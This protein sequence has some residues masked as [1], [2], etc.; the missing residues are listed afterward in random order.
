MN[1]NQNSQIERARVRRN[2]PTADLD[3]ETEGASQALHTPY[4]RSIHSN[5]T[6]E[7]SHSRAI[8]PS[9]RLLS[10]LSGH[11]GPRPA[12]RGPTTLARS[13]SPSSSTRTPM[14]LHLEQPMDQRILLGLNGATIQKQ[15]ALQ[16][17]L[18]PTPRDEMS[19]ISSS[20]SLW[21]RMQR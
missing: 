12:E 11:S 6:P 3:E 19:T 17:R 4:D 15:P 10:L 8:S 5:N 2:Q 14:S 21:S 7:H 9:E 18:S 16:P 20:A 13:S 1:A